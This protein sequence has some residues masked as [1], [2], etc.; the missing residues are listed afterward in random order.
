M[1]RVVD[2]EFNKVNALITLGSMYRNATEAIKEYVSNAL[3]EWAIAKRK[4]K[5]KGPC[6][7]Q[8]IL[9]RKSIT[10]DYNAPGMDE[11]GF[12]EALKHVVD[13]PKP[14]YDTPQIGRLG[15]GLW[16]FNQ[17]GSQAVFYS[18]RTASSP[19][20]KVTLRR[21]SS[22]A[23]F[24]T[25]GAGE[26]RLEPGMTIVITGLF[27]D[28]TRRYGPLSPSR[29]RHVLADRFDAYL[30][31]EELRIAV[32]CGR[33][34][35]QVEPL[36]L[37]LPEIGAKF[38]AVPLPKDP[39][40]VF[41]TQFWFDPSGHGRVSIRHM[42]VVVVDDLRSALEYNLEETLYT[43][44]SIK[45]F[46]DADFLEPLPARA[47]F[48]ENQDMVALFN[49]LQ[50]MAPELAREVAVFQ[51][52]EENERRLGLIQRAT[53]IAREILSQE[54]FLDLELIEGLTRI[55]PRSNGAD[56]A[57]AM[58]TNRPA[59]RSKSNGHDVSGTP[60][61][62]RSIV[63]QAVFEDDLRRRS[64][65]SNGTIEI[66]VTNPDFLAL[67][68]VPRTHQVAYIAMLLG[69]EIIAYNDASGVSDE[70]LE[71]MVAYGTKVLSRVWV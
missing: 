39:G 8:F 70:A 52:E 41:R 22:S 54:E 27:Q 60:S 48:V 37:D 5:A 45:G 50:K 32:L 36:H 7:V 42:G 71:K 53:R 55:R 58:A 61:T 43:S 15:I 46:I 10:I 44:G 21:N 47:Q 49:A 20:L 34:A 14:G 24:S 63:R 40:K 4:G 35:H 12:E 57:M 56:T 18:K 69:K 62:V 9:A 68:D 16:A 13:S 17:V 19:T 65:L 11:K 67:A 23:E 25:P 51:E 28:P 64:R 33:E 2:V 38:R 29:L 66:N 3:D 26:N 30:R 1:S 6:Q 59:Q 31:A